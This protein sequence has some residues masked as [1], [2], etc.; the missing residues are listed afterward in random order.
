[1]SSRLYLIPAPLGDN[2]PQEVIPPYV[3]SSIAHIRHF[4]VE[5]IRSARRY[6]SRA[7]FKGMVDSLSF[8]EINE[9]SS[10]EDIEGVFNVLESVGEMAL[11]SE[12]GLPAVADPGAAL[13]AL[14]H[15]ADMEVIPMSGPSSLM[16]ALMSSGMN[17]QCFA[18]AGYLPVKPEQRRRSIKELEARSRKYSET[19]I[20]IE[21]P[22]RSDALFHDILAV[23]G[24]STLVCAASDLTLPDQSIR[25]RTV[26]EWKRHPLTIS[27]KPT[28]FLILA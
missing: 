27:K 15:K 22:Y 25:T 5:D 24:P 26:A 10:Q 4:A 28:V 13:V 9:H 23:C 8:Y 21:T 11:I 12:A 20:M 16:M 3:F 14:A 17:G 1:M 18:F 2:P 6:L 7:G 19:E